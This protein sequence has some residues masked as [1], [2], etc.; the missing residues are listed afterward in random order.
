MDRREPADNRRQ[1]RLDEMADRMGSAMPDRMDELLQD[2]RAK[3]E[4]AI[5]QVDRSKARIDRGRARSDAEQTTI[6]REGKASERRLR[7]RSEK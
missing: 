4:R 7:D 6:E 2:A 5:Q 1:V 3:L